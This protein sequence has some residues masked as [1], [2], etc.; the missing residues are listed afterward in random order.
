MRRKKRKHRVFLLGRFL[1][2]LGAGFG[3]APFSGGAEKG[4]KMLALDIAYAMWIVAALLILVWDL[5]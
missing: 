5:S 4:S 1:P 3:L 2:N